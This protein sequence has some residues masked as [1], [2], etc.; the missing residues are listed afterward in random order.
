MSNGLQIDAEGKVIALI[1]GQCVMCNA[2]SQWYIERDSADVF[3]FASLQSSVGRG[4]LREGGMPESGMDT[5]VL[6]DGG[7]YYTRSTAALRALRRLGGRWRLVYGAI[8][9]PKFIRDGVYRYIARNRYRWFGKAES[10]PIPT[11]QL[12][13]KFLDWDEQ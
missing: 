4:L 2:I 10:C 3:R 11:P 6:I 13:G 12:R 5:F 1:D 7:R 9:V 8:I